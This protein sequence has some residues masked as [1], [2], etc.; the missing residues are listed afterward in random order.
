MK[1]PH[2]KMANDT[3]RFSTR[4]AHNASIIHELSPTKTHD[5]T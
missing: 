3:W 2:T 4:Y 5:R 1:T